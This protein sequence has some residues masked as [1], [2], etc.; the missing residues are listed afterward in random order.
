MINNGFNL[1]S[2]TRMVAEHCD[3]VILPRTRMYDYQ[4]KD[5]FDHH[6]YFYRLRRDNDANRTVF[7][8]RS[9][10]Y[11]TLDPK[12]WKIDET[13]YDRTTLICKFILKNACYLCTF[14]FT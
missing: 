2:I 13:E 10:M 8:L 1:H 4:C 12:Y 5:S 14:L 3:R 7:S 9:E 6:G 11:Y